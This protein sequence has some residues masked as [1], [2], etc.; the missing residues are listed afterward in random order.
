MTKEMTRAVAILSCVAVFALVAAAD[1][2]AA[3]APKVQSTVG[4]VCTL[5]ADS[6][7]P[8]TDGSTPPLPQGAPTPAIYKEVCPA[9]FTLQL[10]QFPYRP[11]VAELRASIDYDCMQVSQ[12]ELG[13]CAQIDKAMD[14]F[15]VPVQHR[16]LYL[17]LDGQRI[18]TIN[19][20]K[21]H[22]DFGIGGS[23]GDFADQATT[24][25]FEEW[26]QATYEIG[27]LRIPKREGWHRLQIGMLGD[28]ALFDGT[29][30][31]ARSTPVW[32]WVP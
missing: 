5:V 26:Y 4:T 7:T 20:D 2:T 9:T 19:L 3:S 24:L 11:G 13:T 14:P 22:L 21:T 30:L 31:E 18:K 28:Q 16:P 10:Q 23:A 25:G 17:Y 15:T 27:T 12:L 6:A 8:T 29:T 32:F 1:A